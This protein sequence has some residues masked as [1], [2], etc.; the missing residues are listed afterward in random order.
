MESLVKPPTEDELFIELKTRIKEHETLN[1]FSDAID[2]KLLLGFLRG[3]KKNLDS[4]ISCLEK[5]IDMRTVKYAT[6][7]RTYRPSTISALNIGVLRLLKKLDNNGRVVLVVTCNNWQ[8]S[9]TP[10][11]ELIASSLFI[12]DEGIR[13]HFSIGNELVV[14]FD[15]KGLGFDQARRLTPS[16]VIM[17]LDMF[18]KC[19]PSRPKAFHVVHAGY[20]MHGLYRM[21][22]PFLKKK[23]QDRVHVHAKLTQLADHVPASILPTKLGGEMLEDDA[24]DPLIMERV[25]GN[26][27]YYEGLSKL[28]AP[29]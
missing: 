3:K 23:L 1:C 21:V 28:S 5:Y 22:H 29:D 24:Y 25:K 8:P 16:Y 26:D 13:T 27:E 14:I 20:L 15:C 17:G 2:D 7:T 9:Q 18:L 12:M 19:L 10:L 4:T 11:E 6:F